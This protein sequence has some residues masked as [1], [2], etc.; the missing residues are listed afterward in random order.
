MVSK[1]SLP[2]FSSAVIVVLILAFIICIS[3]ISSGKN[4]KTA[5]NHDNFPGPANW[6]EDKDVLALCS[7]GG[8]RWIENNL[9]YRI[10]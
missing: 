2:I 6:N 3:V 5:I 1:L 10:R 8:S 4:H 9:I 7:L